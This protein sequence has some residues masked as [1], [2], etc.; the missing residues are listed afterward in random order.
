MRKFK[1][2]SLTFPL[3]K[4]VFWKLASGAFVTYTKIFFHP[5][6]LV[7]LSV[8]WATYICINSFLLYICIKTQICAWYS[9]LQK[10]ISSKLIFFLQETFKWVEKNLSRPFY[11][12]QFYSTKTFQLRL[13]DNLTT[14]K[15]FIFLERKRC[16]E[17]DMNWTLI[18]TKTVKISCRV[19]EPVTS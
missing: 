4:L 14:S 11:T 2:K 1:Y 16:W 8:H 19:P 13:I 7:D 18:S 15:T 12:V 10:K 9:F 3:Q 17:V 5:S 6:L